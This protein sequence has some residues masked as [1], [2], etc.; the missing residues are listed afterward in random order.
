MVR[1]DEVRFCSSTK[2]SAGR[3]CT[4][5]LETDCRFFS[6]LYTLVP[7][8]TFAQTRW[9]WE[10]A[11]R[12]LSALRRIKEWCAEKGL[13]EVSIRRR[14]SAR[15]FSLRHGSAR[16]TS[17]ATRRVFWVDGSG[18]WVGGMVSRLPFLL[19][20]SGLGKNSCRPS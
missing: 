14:V 2:R 1:P 13:P 20:F 11:L 16:A 4:Q 6:S 10:A 9:F 5:H 17:R 8:S 19:G 18:L 3:S 7:S 15:C 12:M